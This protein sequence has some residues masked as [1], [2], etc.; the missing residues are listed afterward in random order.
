MIKEKTNN[1][2]G[3]KGKKE[4]NIDKFEFLTKNGTRIK[5]KKSEKERINENGK[6]KIKELTAEGFNPLISMREINKYIN[7]VKYLYSD[8]ERSERRGEKYVTDSQSIF[9]G[10]NFIENL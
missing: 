8:G 2:R 7:M 1:R 6:K 3:R 4:K 10:F 5:Q 9:I